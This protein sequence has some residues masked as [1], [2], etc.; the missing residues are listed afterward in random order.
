[1]PNRLA[2]LTGL[3]NLI[4]RDDLLPEIALIECFAEEPFINRLTSYIVN[5]FGSIRN[6]KYAS[7]NL[8]VTRCLAS[9][10]MLS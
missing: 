7:F 8:S 1:M 5:V 2:F 4:Q 6:A 9:R 10:K 3:F